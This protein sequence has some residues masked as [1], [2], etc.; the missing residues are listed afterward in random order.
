MWAVASFDQDAAEGIIDDSGPLR[1]EHHNTTSW[2][3]PKCPS[4]TSSVSMS[5]FCSIK[6]DRT[7]AFF[8]F[9]VILSNF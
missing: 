6:K 9:K 8:L 1:E 7:I 3:S 5:T 2:P 4:P